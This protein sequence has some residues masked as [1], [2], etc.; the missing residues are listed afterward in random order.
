MQH[1]GGILLVLSPP[2]IRTRFTAE[3]GIMPR[4]FIKESLRKM[5]EI[6]VSV[7][8]IVVISP[9]GSSREATFVR[10]GTDRIGTTLSRENTQNIQNMSSNK[11]EKRF[12]SVLSSPGENRYFI[13]ISKVN[14]SGKFAEGLLSRYTYDFLHLTRVLISVEIVAS[15][16]RTATKSRIMPK[17]TARGT[18]SGDSRI[19][20]CLLRHYGDPLKF[21]RHNIFR[22]IKIR[23]SAESL[24]R[25][26]GTG[27]CRLAGK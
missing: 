6:R 24:R 4:G 12:S 15:F 13:I 23:S 1:S 10:G 5:Y 20:A 16:A 8:D 7:R 21:H 19:A 22:D 2:G 9:S 25:W 26:L 14:P 3:R 18:K 11:I 27:E 17:L